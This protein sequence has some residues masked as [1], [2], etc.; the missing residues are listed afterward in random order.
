MFLVLYVLHDE[1]L[2]SE[3]LTAWE[4]VGVGGITVLTSTGMGRINKYNALREDIPLIPSLS[5]L[6]QDHDELFNRTLFTIVDGQEMVDRLVEA[7]EQVA[8]KMIDHNTGILAVLPI[9]QVYG[10]R[11]REK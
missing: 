9:A 7:T 4:E 8:G 10:L 6:L 1:T 3:I 5:I 2:L 11:K